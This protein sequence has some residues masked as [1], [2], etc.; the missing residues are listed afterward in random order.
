MS[1]DHA[2]GDQLNAGAAAL[3][4]ALSA[5]QGRIL[6]QYLDLLVKWNK[7]YNLT[8]LR[9]AAQMVTQ[10]LLDSLAVLPYVKGSRLLDVGSGAG[11]PGIV[12]AVAQPRLHCTLLDSRGKKTRFLTQTRIELNL[13][14]VE[15]VQSRLENYVP[16]H[17]FDTIVSRAFARLA[18]FADLTR[19]LLAADG[20]L[21]AMKGS[22]EAEL[23]ESRLNGGSVYPID[24]PGLDKQRHLV[25]MDAAV[26]GRLSR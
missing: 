21:L 2:L 8:G 20:R 17:A 14:N 22:D 15:V 19:G 23:E 12:L 4:V 25:V 6:L 24:V 9:E 7:T 1:N 16:A 5:T 13:E 18:E 10:H 11:L 26:V 3:G